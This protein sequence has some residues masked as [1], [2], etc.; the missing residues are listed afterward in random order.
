MLLSNITY[1]TSL[2]LRH[3]LALNFVWMF[4]GWAPSKYVKICVPP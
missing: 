4:S 1:L 2:K 3:G